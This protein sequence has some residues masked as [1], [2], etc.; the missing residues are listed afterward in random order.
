MAS[1]DAPL[2]AE[3]K[4]QVFVIPS[5][6]TG[7]LLPMTDLAC[8][9]ATHPNVEPTIMTTPANAALIRSTLH[10]S[11][12]MGH[13]VKLLTYPFPSVGLPPGIENLATVPESD[14]WRIYKAHDMCQPAH[15][16]ILKAHKPDAVIAD[17]PFWWVTDI[18]A[19]VSIPRITFHPVGVFP[20][21]VMNNL[22][23]IRSDIIACDV[24]HAKMVSV[25]GLP[26]PEINIPV[27]ELP[28]FLVEE[29]F[30]A[31]IWMKI[32][33]AQL[34]GFGVVVNTF[35]ELEPEY[36][37]LY[38][39][40]D[41]KRAYFVGPVA[42]S[43]G[44]DDQGIVKRGGD[45]DV[46]CLNWLDG[47][48]MGSVVFVCF[49][50][51]CHFTCAQLRELA[52]GLEDSGKNFLWVVRGGEDATFEWMPEKW[53]ERIGL[54]GLV[55]R[56]WAPQVAIL[57][58][59]AVG[60]FLTHC[61]WNSLLEATS[62]G[63][64]VLTWPLVFEQFI[65]ER[66]PVEVNGWGVRVWEGGNRGMKQGEQ[67]VVPREAIAD[68]VSKFMEHGG[69]SDEVRGKARE[70]AVMAKAAMADGGTSRNDLNRLIDD[71][72]KE[73]KVNACLEKKKKN[74]VDDAYV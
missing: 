48:E 43:S 16:S 9:L 15:E 38:K 13:L 10:R 36:C 71:L 2:P 5:F 35:Y 23:N 4:L 25:P 70:M 44:E 28:T 55:V 67:E 37:E 30:L 27:S 73:R 3:T 60:A 26:G 68:T 22:F 8:L 41:A 52:H 21:V 42:L 54:R 69:N 20:Q 1:L 33:K 46:A 63:V 59:K 31:D 14:E 11:F 49:G 65:N 58:H 45:G 53:E 62:S 19:V 74:H 32:K 64:P 47:K 6:A 12:E 40:V 61:G 7:H 72:M 17:I 34:E 51:W 24:S 66:M 18:A 29:N 50:S 56:G 39:K 57:Q